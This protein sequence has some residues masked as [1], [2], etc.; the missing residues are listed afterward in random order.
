M[1][2]YNEEGWTDERYHNGEDVSVLKN[3]NNK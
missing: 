1:S 2:D 3:L